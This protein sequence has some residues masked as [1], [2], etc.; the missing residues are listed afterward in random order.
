M[1]LSVGHIISKAV[2]KSSNISDSLTRKSLLTKNAELISS[3]LPCSYQNLH[4][5]YREIPFANGSSFGANFTNV[6]AQVSENSII[7]TN[8]IHAIEQWLKTKGN[9]C[10]HFT[11]F[12][13]LRLTITPTE[14]GQTSSEKYTNPGGAVARYSRLYEPYVRFSTTKLTL[15]FN[16]LH[17]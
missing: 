6:L 5:N 8:V 12:F 10:Y 14:M 11:S 9:I 3:L 16:R 7:N 4:G 1:L 2:V 15:A 13:S 17:S